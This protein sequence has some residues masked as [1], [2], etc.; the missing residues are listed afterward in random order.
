MSV[1]LGFSLLG[2][3]VSLVT[4][5]HVKSNLLQPSALL[6]RS[7][8]V[9]FKPCAMEEAVHQSL[10]LCS[11]SCQLPRQQQLRP[12]PLTRAAFCG[13]PT[14]WQPVK[15]L[16][17]CSGLAAVVQFATINMYRLLALA[18]SLLRTQ[19]IGRW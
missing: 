16:R 3:A 19:S 4:Y 10:R 8:V 13:K 2:R 6:S 5:V 9:M 17:T 12:V 7:S 15:A 1:L 18:E 14:L 11:C